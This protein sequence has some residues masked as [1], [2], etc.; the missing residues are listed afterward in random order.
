MNLN[1]R[2]SVLLSGMLGI[3]LVAALLFFLFTVNTLESQVFT[4]EQSDFLSYNRGRVINQQALTTNFYHGQLGYNEVD[5]SVAPVTANFTSWQNEVRAILQARFEEQDGVSVTLYDLDFESSYHFEHATT[6]VSTTL[7]LIFP[8]P[9]NL[10]TLNGVRFLVDDQ[11]PDNVQYSSQSI[12]WL[13]TLLPG[14][15]Y[16]ITIHY[17]ADGANSFVYGLNQT[18]R[19]NELNIELTI[20]GLTGSDV[21]RNSLPTTA[22][23][24]SE[25]TPGETLIWQYDN[26]VANR[27]IHLTLPQRLSFTQRIATLQDDF[28]AMSNLAILLLILFLVSTAVVFP[29][30]HI[31]LSSPSYLLLGL[32]FILF[33]PLL[34]FLSGVVGPILAAILAV[35]TVAGLLIFFVKQITHTS[36]AV[37]WVSWLLFVLLGVVS[38][39]MLTPW[40]SLL[41]TGGGFLLVAG[42]MMAYARRPL[43][44]NI[45]PEQEDEEP[46]IIVEEM[47]AP[48]PKPPS[49]LP[50]QDEEPEIIVE[51]MSAPT[52]KPLSPLPAQPVSFHAHCPQCG[53]GLNEDYDFCPGC[54]YNGQHIKHCP[55]CGHEHIATDQTTHFCVHCGEKL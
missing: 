16:N 25:T 33:Y 9:D 50:A 4:A 32:G 35:I 51:E 31:Q 6:A 41:L 40:R 10:E 19:T 52:P 7:E 45:E 11:E 55:A 20:V 39:G 43:P 54:G 49:P 13:T 36:Q 34:T 27:D 24:I 30:Y 15:A 47:S 1:K 21:P 29:W 18:R 12:R 48:T 23:S 17:R 53:R 37:Y 28:R 46:K 2:A 5:G 38:L 3:G 26:L 44:A 22:V 42:W 8:F 14:E